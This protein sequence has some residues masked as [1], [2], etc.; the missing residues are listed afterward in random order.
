MSPGDLLLHQLV[1]LVVCLGLG[2]VALRAIGLSPKVSL[3]GSFRWALGV[4]GHLARAL[5]WT[6]PVSLVRGGGAWWGDTA[7]DLRCTNGCGRRIPATA[8]VTCSGCGYRCRRSVFAPC[9]CCGT[10]L[11]H[12][13]CPHCRVSV[14]RPALWTQPQPDRRYR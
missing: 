7:T 13:R 10:T 6:L 3:V 2:S 14:P 4:G 9:R 11:R 5:L 12:F 8:L 1:T